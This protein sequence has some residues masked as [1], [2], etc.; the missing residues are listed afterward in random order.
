MTAQPVTAP[1]Q[2]ADR[3]PVAAGEEPADWL[4]ICPLQRLQPFRGVAALVS[5]VQV[6]V[7]RHTD[8]ALFA[9]G[10]IDPFSGAAVMSR[11]IV[12]DRGGE[13]T[14]AGPIYKQSF[15]LRDGRCLDDD[16]VSLPAFAVRC[17]GGAV[18]LGIR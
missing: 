10:N 14:V 13:P 9:V 5:D 17:V 2:V 3:R 4:T 1:S 7:F 16:A 12:G 8:D 15:A 18:Q 11:G 6:A